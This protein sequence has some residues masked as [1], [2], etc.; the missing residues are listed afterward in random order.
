MSLIPVGLECRV[1]HN[2]TAGA[3]VGCTR[4]PEFQVPK[5]LRWQEVLRA[6]QA[7]GEHRG[8]LFQEQEKVGELQSKMKA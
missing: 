7:T 4:H 5:H 6:L 8:E 1:T 2:S 3:L